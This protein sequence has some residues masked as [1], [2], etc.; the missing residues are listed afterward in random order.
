MPDTDQMLSLLRTM[1]RIREFEHRLGKFY[2]YSAYAALGKGQESDRTEALLT[3]TLYDFASSGMIGGAVHLYVGQEA[4]A[5]GVCAHMRDDDYVTG[6]HRG[7]GHFIGKGGSVATAM[8]EL[9]GRTG[10]CSHGYG[11]S[12]HLFDPAKGFL[13]GNGIIG[14]QIPLALGPAF[15]A[16]YN[17]TDG[18]SAAFFGDGGANQ[19][20]LY[21]S[22]NIAALWKLPVLFVCENNLYAATTPQTISSARPDYAPRAEGFGMPGVIVDGQ[23]VLAVYEVAGEAIARARAGDGPTFI[24]A[25]T[26]RFYGHCGAESEHANAEEC[27]L[28]QE[29]DPI[30]LLKAKLDAG[31][32]AEV[33]AAVNRELDEAEAYAVASPLPEADEVERFVF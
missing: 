20:T 9:M 18:V 28:W 23:D 3:S 29:R 17:G 24:E 16:K 22:M 6:S 12:M 30:E 31:D 25:K 7:H 8:A 10:G 5:T 32:V 19:G 33:E 1:L 11:G 15:A 27:A 21:E 2:N 14:A 13:G 4:V 26:F